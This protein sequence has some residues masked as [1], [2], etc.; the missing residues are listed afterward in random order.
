MDMFPTMNPKPL[1]CGFQ[2]GLSIFQLAA[3][4]I[5]PGSVLNPCYW[6][7]FANRQTIFTHQGRDAI[8]LICKHWGLGPEDEVLVPA[9]NCGSEVDPL[10]W[11]V[12]R[13]VL[14]RVDSKTNI[15][16]DDIRNRIT[17]RTKLLYVTHYFGWPQDI[18]ELT[19]YCR[20]RNILVLEDCALSLFSSGPKVPIGHTGDAAIF[21][22]PKTLPVPDGGA[23]ILRNAERDFDPALK[24]PD[25]KDILFRTLPLLQINLI[26]TAERLCLYPLARKLFGKN[27]LRQ[28]TSDSDDSSGYPDI[29]YSY[30][31]DSETADWSASRITKRILARV[32]ADEIISR[33]RSNYLYL[34]NSLQDVVGIKPL[35]QTL[36]TGV[37][38]LVFPVLVSNRSRWVAELNNRGVSGIAWWSGYHHGLRW[39]EFTEAHFL[40]DR[41]LVLPIHQGLDQSHI[42][43]IELCVRYIATLIN[44]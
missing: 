19:Q 25:R 32:I 24:P 40:K 7:Q 5:R 20:S 38:P 11:C 1:F 31:F 8:A 6:P 9:Y 39:D 34:H 14:Y 16:P 37:C 42:E 35:F 26:R 27:L 23:L 41:L 30:Y 15:D 13:V 21:S 33:R 4:L 28:D 43:Y 29:P 17:N 12:C 10:L 36:P 2:P 3:D 44:N 22:F 18:E